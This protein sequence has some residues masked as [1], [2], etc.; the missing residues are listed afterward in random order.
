MRRAWYASCWCALAAAACAAACS[1]DTGPSGGSSRLTGRLVAGATNTCALDHSGAAFCWGAGSSGQLGNGGMAESPT[2]VR[3]IGGPYSALSATDNAVCG[4][5]FDGAVD[6]WG[7]LVD[8]CCGQPVP[9]ATVAV[10]TRVAS[11][12]RFSHI[13]L[14]ALAMCG[15][16]ASHRAFCWGDESNGALG[17]GVDS[18]TSV[19][20]VTPLAGGHV[21][22]SL[23]EGVFGG[24]GLDGTGQAWCWGANIFG[25]LGTG[26]ESSLTVASTPVAVS[27]G[28]RFAQLSVGAAYACGVTT[29]GTTVCWGNNIG[30]ALGDG[31]MTG[32]SSPTPVM[33]AHFV[34]VFAGAKNDIV[35]HTCA[36]DATGA[37]SCW[38]TNESGQLGGPSTEVCNFGNG[39]SCST[40]PVAVGGGLTFTT[41]ALGNSHTCGMVADGHVYCWGRNDEGELGDGTTTTSMAPVL[42]QFTP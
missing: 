7:G 5:R 34:T 13:S 20:P 23:S 11:A 33:G 38:G 35:D 39:L 9:R 2:P 12:I 10:P 42:S 37:A 15:L 6:C 26:D 4:L 32:R 22:A 24:C 18:G 27:G 3:V 21:F 14:G 41:L 28:L 31:T 8:A 19:P 36:L 40:S 1:S 29:T 30:A 17:N 25:E 16:D